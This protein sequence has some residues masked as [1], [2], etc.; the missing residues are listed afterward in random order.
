VLNICVAGLIGCCG[1]FAALLAGGIAGLLAAREEQASTKG[2]GARLG[3]VSGAIAGAFVLVGQ[4]I[5]G[6]GTLI[7]AQVSEITLPFGE[8]PDP[9][10]GLSAQVPYYFAGLG[11]AICF[12]LVGIVLAALAGAGAGY[13]GTPE[14]VAL[15]G[16]E[17]ADG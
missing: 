6:V 16:S 3:A 8:V 13:L 10:A 9:S 5:G 2:E 11:V 1:P 7:F 15:A 4:M 14:D 12:G 17:G